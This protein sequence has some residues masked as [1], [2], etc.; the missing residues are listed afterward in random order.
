[1]ENR[2]APGP[3]LGL[4]QRRQEL[5]RKVD[6][7]RRARR[8][9]DVQQVGQVGAGAFD[10]KQAEQPDRGQLDLLQAG[11]QRAL[12]LAQPLDEG[13]RPGGIVQRAR[14]RPATAS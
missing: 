12:L 10:G 11:E 3:A 6:D 9:D 5:Q 1:M 8:T 7:V 4:E 2:C 13:Q 14:A